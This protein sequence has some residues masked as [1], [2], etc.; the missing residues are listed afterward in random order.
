[1]HDRQWQVARVHSAALSKGRAP[2][3]HR[4]NAKAAARRV[5]KG[6]SEPPPLLEAQRHF[7]AA[8]R[9]NRSEQTARSQNH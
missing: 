9:F 5:I 3:A 2:S 8:G 7:P 4:N 1:M 6:R